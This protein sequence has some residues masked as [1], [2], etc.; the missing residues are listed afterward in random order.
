MN[1]HEQSDLVRCPKCRWTGD[2]DEC[3]V[4][5]ADWDCVFCPKCDT[6]FVSETG[7]IRISRKFTM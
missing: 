6:E 5:G 1:D 3:D 7:E 2:L 4:V